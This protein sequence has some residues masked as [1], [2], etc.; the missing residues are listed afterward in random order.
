[1]LLSDIIRS[2]I[3][4]TGTPAVRC[5]ESLG[6]SPQSFSQRLSRDGFDLEEAETIIERC[7]AELQI[8]VYKQE[9]LEIDEE[10]A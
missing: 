1:M 2:V 4:K 10:E 6:I 5:A 7:G 8:S 9:L 3:K